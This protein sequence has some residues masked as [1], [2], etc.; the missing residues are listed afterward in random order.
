MSAG[1]SELLMLSIKF[2]LG[3]VA[4]G[5]TARLV[6][7]FIWNRKKPKPPTAPGLHYHTSMPLQDGGVGTKLYQITPKSL[8]PAGVKTGSYSPICCE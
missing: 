1:I 2:G 5:Q 7:N 6:Q 4:V 3:A 8:P